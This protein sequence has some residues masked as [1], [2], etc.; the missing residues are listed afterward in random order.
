MESTYTPAIFSI[1]L[2]PNPASVG[3]MVFVSIEAVDI[4]STPATAEYRSGEFYAG[5]V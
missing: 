1:T 4:E 3:Q 2:T 5:E